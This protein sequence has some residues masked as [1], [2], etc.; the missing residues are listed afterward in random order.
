MKCTVKSVAYFIV[1][2][3]VTLIWGDHVALT[4][5]QD[6]DRVSHKQDLEL[7][8][9]YTDANGKTRFRKL[10]MPYEKLI[11]TKGGMFSRSVRRPEAKP[12][13]PN[14]MEGEL[15]AAPWRRYMVTLSGSRRLIGSSGEVFTADPSHIL[16]IEDTWGD[17]HTFLAG[18]S[19]ET[20]TVFLE[21]DEITPRDRLLS[22]CKAP[23][24][25][26]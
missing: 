2:L 24:C 17:G 20:I 26:P 16:L 1:L 4:A 7:W 11:R 13:D 14:A 9:M 23:A 19:D 5:Q 25:T 12:V 10:E 6:K 18:G 8:N 15:H 22:V 21:V 3:S